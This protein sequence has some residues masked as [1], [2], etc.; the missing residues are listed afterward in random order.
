MGSFNGEL[1]V[2]KN[3][4]FWIG[5]FGLGPR[6]AAVQST[7]ANPKSKILF[8]P[9]SIH[10]TRSASTRYSREPSVSLMILSD[11]TGTN[12]A[13]ATTQLSARS[14]LMRTSRWPLSLDR[15][16]RSW[17]GESGIEH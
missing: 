16:L 1:L 6:F 2:W 11:S 8:Y 12:K 5:D 7:I 13:P 4:G 14:N 3:F 9:I 10:T 17:S 15:A